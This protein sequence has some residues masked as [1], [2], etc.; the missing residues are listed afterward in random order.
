MTQAEQID[1]GSFG[2]VEAY[3]RS[4]RQ[5]MLGAANVEGVRVEAV[6]GDGRMVDGDRLCASGDGDVAPRGDLVGQ[7]VQRQRR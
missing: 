2:G 1:D 5:R 3:G 7:L 6:P 4:I